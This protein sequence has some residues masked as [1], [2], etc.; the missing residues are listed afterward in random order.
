MNLP[1]QL[2]GMQVLQQSLRLVCLDDTR[3]Q[4]LYPTS[5]GVGIL[6]RPDTGS[7]QV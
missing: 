6:D 5:V 2:A 1:V 4:A 3:A 7:R